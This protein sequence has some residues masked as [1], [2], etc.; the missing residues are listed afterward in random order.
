MTKP[1]AAPS[2][3]KPNPWRIA[4]WTLAVLLLLLPLVA[5]QFTTEVDWT[6]ADFVFAAVLIGGVGLAI[7]LAFRS[8]RNGAYRLAVALFVGAAFL[9]VWIN[10]AVGIIGGEDNP[11]NLLYAG[12]LAIACAG[13]VVARFRARGMARAMSVAAAAQAVV[14][15][16]AVIA[17]AHLPPGPLGLIVLNGG[18]VAMFAASAVLFGRAARVA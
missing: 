18:F 14:G 13:A 6:A 1:D 12:V 7:E 16:I 3:R 17:E 2:R 10:A 5:M 15:I 11:L 8:N 4:G 9:L